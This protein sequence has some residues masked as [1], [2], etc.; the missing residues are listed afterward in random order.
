MSDGRGDLEE[1]MEEVG[2]DLKYRSC[3]K[4]HSSGVLG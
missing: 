3:F 4:W 1:E 2:V